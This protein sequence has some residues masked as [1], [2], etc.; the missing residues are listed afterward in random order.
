MQRESDI[1]MGQIKLSKTI[2]INKINNG[3]PIIDATLTRNDFNL[4]IEVSVTDSDGIGSFTYQWQQLDINAVWEDIPA[5][6]DAAYTVPQSASVI[7]HYR[8]Q[9]VYTDAQGYEYRGQAAE[10]IEF[11]KD[12]D[13]DDDALIEIYYLEHL[14]AVRYD[15]DGTHYATTSNAAAAINRGCKADSCNG[16]ELARDLDFFDDASYI[17]L[18]NKAIWTSDEPT[19]GWQPIGVIG[20]TVDNYNNAGI[21]CVSDS[22][23]CF[24]GIFEGNGHTISNLRLR[25][26][27][28]RTID[29]GLFGNTGDRS[30]IR[31]L[32]LLN[33]DS[34]HNMSQYIGAL[35]GRNSSDI[36][37]AY[38][39]VRFQG[40]GNTWIGGLAG[41]NSGLIVNSYAYYDFQAEQDNTAAGLIGNHIRGVNN[42]YA[43]GMF[44]SRARVA[45]LLFRNEAFNELLVTN[46]YATGG[47]ALIIEGVM[48][49]LT[50]YWRDQENIA[51][52]KLPTAPGTSGSEIYNGWSAMNWDFGTSDQFP[53]IKYVNECVTAGTAKSDIGQPICGTL[54]PNQGFGLRDL[55][56]LTDG[57]SDVNLTPAFNSEINEYFM[58]LP[59][60]QQNFKFRLKAYDRNAKISIMRQRDNTEYFGNASSG[61][62]S[63]IP[64][65]DGT[66][67]TIVVLGS[68][69]E[70][71][72]TTRTRYTLKRRFP[73][74]EE[75]NI[76]VTEDGV[77]DNDEMV[78]EGSSII[79]NA[80]IIGGDGNFRYVWTQT[81]GDSLSLSGQSA[82]A[83]GFQ[84]T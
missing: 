41:V 40:S 3:I 76:A 79:L 19:K 13:I 75:V 31:N 42:S 7:R 29:I 37:N 16:Y 59:H 17:S 63:D 66:T 38:V 60:T 70:T 25:N 73:D 9:L 71:K 14:N 58:V 56:I 34:R 28:N 33:V 4:S 52:L 61:D 2:V 20:A 32:G 65:T 44:H 84:I 46:N 55:E 26:W 81:G 12:V 82:D 39:N 47:S 36:T 11:R 49:S 23:E 5:A 48:S 51:E 8:V 45:G 18:A 50:N 24:T 67:L 64:L 10:A 69:I 53:V 74:V 54:L 77:A 27:N 1:A 72:A 6:T 30:A 78:N 15:L 83:L 62:S 22:I 80:D 43:R 57:V 35:V 21:F 68:S